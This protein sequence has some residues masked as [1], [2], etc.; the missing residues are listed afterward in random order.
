MANMASCE[1]KLLLSQKL[2]SFHQVSF[3]GWFCPQLWD[4]PSQS[5]WKIRFTSQIVFSA[6]NMPAQTIIVTPLTSLQSTF[7]RVNLPI[8][9]LSMSSCYLHT[10]DR[11]MS[12]FVKQ[13]VFFSQTN[14]LCT[15]CSFS[16]VYWGFLTISP[17][18]MRKQLS[19]NVEIE[20][21]SNV[22][23]LRREKRF[24]LSSKV[25][26]HVSAW[27]CRHTLVSENPHQMIFKITIYFYFGNPV[28]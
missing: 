14:H 21:A 24:H 11:Y 27:I 25:K 7:R 5:N 18:L 19:F 12:S 8:V 9:H 28:E 10:N 23:M 4:I 2:S 26:N 20:N 16:K 1:Y 22:R 15:V 3:L 13:H 17:V 6:Q